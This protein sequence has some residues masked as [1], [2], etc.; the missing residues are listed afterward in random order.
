[1]SNFI[2]VAE[3]SIGKYESVVDDITSESDD[4]I[5]ELEEMV[6]DEITTYL[7]SRYDTDLIFRKRGK[8]RSPLMKRLVV[9]GI[10]CMA[11]S[12]TKSNVI[13]QSLKDRCEKNLKFLDDIAKGKITLGNLPKIE[14]PETG[15]TFGM[16]TSSLFNNK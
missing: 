16:N 7:S 9:D 11:F 13:P 12:R 6:I 1:M 5:F 10:L 14:E 15:G 4:I 2:T 3:I 8:D